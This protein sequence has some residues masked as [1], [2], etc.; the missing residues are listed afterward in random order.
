MQ[1]FGKTIITS[2]GRQMLTEVDGAKGKIAYTKASICTQD[3]N[4]FSESD[5]MELTALEGVQMNTDLEVTDVKDTTVT[6]LASFNNAKVTKDLTF[7]SIGW[8]AKTSV[9]DTEKL[10]AITPSESEQALVAGN[11]GASTSSIDIEMVFGRSHDTTVVVEPS[12][13]GLVSKA[14]LTAVTE[15]INNDIVSAKK[16]SQEQVQDALGD[17]HSIDNP[18]FH[19]GDKD[20][21]DVDKAVEP[22]VHHLTKTKVV[23]TINAN[24]RN[25]VPGGST[26]LTGYLIVNKHDPDN[27]TQILLVYGSA[28]PDL[29]IG[30]RS[31][32]SVTDKRPDFQRL[33]TSQD[34]K[35]IQN[36]IEETQQNTSKTWVGTLEEYQS[37]ATHEPLTVYYIISDYEVVVK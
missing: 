2:V 26:A 3:V 17:I 13:V 33:I 8:F 19:Y 27:I 1:K 15:K 11:N 16:E 4:E 23:S 24:A 31:I 10:L 14:Q 32:S 25:G 36:Q 37:M 9:D 5:L 30:T 20:T 7:N 12:S 28:T 34:Y 18:D 6:V 29:V 35:N 21:L 22:G